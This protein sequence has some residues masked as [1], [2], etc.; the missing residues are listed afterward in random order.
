MGRKYRLPSELSVIL[1]HA[2]PRIV[3]AS[4]QNRITVAQIPRVRIRLRGS[5]DHARHYSLTM[6]LTAGQVGEGICT[7]AERPS[8]GP[9]G[10]WNP[11]Q[12]DPDFHLVDI[13]SFLLRTCLPRSETVYSFSV[14]CRVS[15]GSDH[16][17]GHISRVAGTGPRRIA[18]T[19]REGNDRPRLFTG[20]VD[21]SVQVPPPLSS[22]LVIGSPGPFF[23][24]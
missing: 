2:D 11:F 9:L 19:R 5:E 16:C 22:G 7:L 3:M 4:S 15:S 8:L 6:R 1:V 17:Q 24:V 23:L 13:P 18:M 21:S 12:A 14:H 10:P 20:V